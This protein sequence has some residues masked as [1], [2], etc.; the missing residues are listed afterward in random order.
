MPR[1]TS[2][3]S[4]VGAGSNEKGEKDMKKSAKVEKGKEETEAVTRKVEK[5][6]NCE[7]KESQTKALM[8]TVK[9]GIFLINPSIVAL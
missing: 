1:D 6:K 8:E 3:L 2:E 4:A 9:T 5:C 7:T